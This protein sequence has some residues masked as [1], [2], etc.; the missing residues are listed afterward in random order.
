V[1]I[2]QFILLKIIIY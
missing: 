2:I 1:V